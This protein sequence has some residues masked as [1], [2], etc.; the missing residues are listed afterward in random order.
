MSRIKVS[1]YYKDYNNWCATYVDNHNVLRKWEFVKTC[2]SQKQY[3]KKVNN[4]CVFP[5]RDTRGKLSTTWSAWEGHKYW[6]ATEVDNRAG[7]V[8]TFLKSFRSVLERGPSAK[9][10][11]SRSSFFIVPFSFRSVLSR[12]KVFQFRSVL[13]VLS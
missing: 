13:G 5:F 3:S 12:R 4:K 2:G 7:H 11:R 10:F 1:I 9:L 8:P 6:C